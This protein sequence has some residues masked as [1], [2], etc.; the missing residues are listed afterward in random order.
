LSERRQR[1]LEEISKAEA[2]AAKGVDGAAD[3]LA[4]LNRRLIQLSRDAYGTAGSEYASDRAQA[5]ASAERIIQ[6]ENDRIRGT[7]EAAAETNRQ[8]ATA[9]QLSNEQNNILAE[10][11]AGIR[12]LISLDGLNIAGGGGGNTGIDLGPLA[13]SVNLK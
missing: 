10:I 13:R 8:L 3:R 6:L 9:N 2:D 4:D 12:N 7:Q 5:I 1:L 11:N